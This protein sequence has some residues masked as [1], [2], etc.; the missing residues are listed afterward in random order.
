[1]AIKLT[2]RSRVCAGSGAAALPCCWP[3]FVWGCRALP[4]PWRLLGVGFQRFCLECV[5]AVHLI[6]S[7]AT[8]WRPSGYAA[9]FIRR[10]DDDD[11]VGK[12]LPY[13]L[14]IFFLVPQRLLF[15]WK[16]LV[17]DFFFC[18]D[19]FG[20]FCVVPVMR[21]EFVWIISE[22]M[23]LSIFKSELVMIVI[24]F[25]YYVRKKCFVTM[26]LIWLYVLFLCSIDVY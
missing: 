8:Y 19:F 24:F 7:A 11:G 21:V 3:W 6:R 23:F 17:A 26:F 13:F 10:D 22:I 18:F 14:F 9:P 25:Y 16:Y 20:I 5:S 4:R 12:C 2:V 1:M 15:L